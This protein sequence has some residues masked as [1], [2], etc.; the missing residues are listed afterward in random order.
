MRATENDLNEGEVIC[1][2]C[3]GKK[4]FEVSSTLMQR[5]PKCKGK[6]TLD[7]IENIIGVKG[8]YI[9]PG[10]YTSEVDYS[11]VIRPGEKVEILTENDPWRFERD[12][13]GKK[14]AK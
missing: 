1:N 9:K 3:N 4:E 8:T 6:G 10:I 13:I 7:W 14:C 12:F 2:K 5:C 11:A